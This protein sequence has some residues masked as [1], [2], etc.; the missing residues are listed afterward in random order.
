MST[1]AWNF[2]LHPTY[3]HAPNALV[4][5]PSTAVGD[6]DNDERR[7]AGRD[8]PEG[9]GHDAPPPRRRSLSK[10]SSSITVAAAW[11]ALIDILRPTLPKDKG[12]PADNVAT[13][14]VGFPPVVRSPARPLPILLVVV[15]V[16]V[17]LFVFVAVIVEQALPL[18]FPTSPPLPLPSRHRPRSNAS[19][20]PS[21]ILDMYDPWSARRMPIARS[22]VSLPDDGSV[23]TIA[24]L[25][26]SPVLFFYFRRGWHWG[27]GGGGVAVVCAVVVGGVVVVAVVCQGII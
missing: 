23:Q 14:V 1:T 2:L 4:P 20:N 15:F 7:P 22:A 5:P 9:G 27:G 19:T 11:G 10:S 8:G 6:I 16:V 12:R 17:V 3:D 18:V 25:R 13:V 21:G 24:S 26:I